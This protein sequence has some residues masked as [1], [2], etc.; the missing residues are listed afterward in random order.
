MTTWYCLSSPPIVLTSMT[1]GTQRSFGTISQSRMRAQ[2]HRR[3]LVGADDELVDLA[4]A[5]GDRRQLGLAGDLREAR[6][7]AAHA[8]EHQLAREPDVRAVLEDDGHGREPGARDRAQLDELRQAVE[9][10]LDR[11]GDRSLDLD[12]R[13]PGAVRE[14]RD[15][16][17]RDVGD[18]VDRQVA[19]R[20]AAADE[21]HDEQ[22]E[23]EEADVDR[24][25]DDGS[26]HG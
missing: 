20:D 21:Q 19:R 15:L 18:G 3:V 12:R 16:D 11:E 6:L 25:R 2:L 24:P 26:E 4:E 23:D 5:A 13:E 14:H 1:P 8:L 22:R 7:D 10:G 9:G 17:R